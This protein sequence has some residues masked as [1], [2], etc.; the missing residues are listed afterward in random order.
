MSDQTTLRTSPS[1]SP[2]RRARRAAAGALLG[3][4]VITGPWTVPAAG[5]NAGTGAD[6]DA[7]RDADRNADRDADRDAG[8]RAALLGAPGPLAPAGESLGPV[9]YRRTFHEPIEAGEAHGRLATY[10]FLDD[11]YLFTTHYR[12]ALAA[13]TRTSPVSAY[14]VSA[15]YG[16]PGSWAAGHHTGV[17]F[18]TPTGTAVHSVGP[19]TVVQAEYSGDYGNV[20]MVEMT[21]GYY[22]L[23]AHLSEI[24]V[25]AGE[26]VGTG[27]EIGASGSTGRSTGPHLHFEIRTG[28]GYGSD[29]DP[30]AYLA[31]HGVSVV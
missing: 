16:I 29:V 11:D 8:P 22:A 31:G 14:P 27:T 17:D 15:A 1:R 10:G 28:L 7:D 21:D 12:S 4:L 26:R 23:Y 24:S 5:Q 30:L 25:E 6:Q 9:R 18:A 2:H 13:T 3:A 20:V 19:G